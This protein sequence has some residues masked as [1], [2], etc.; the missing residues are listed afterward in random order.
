MEK[1]DLQAIALCTTPFVAKIKSNL[2]TTLMYHLWKMDGGTICFCQKGRALITVN[3]KEYEIVPNMQAI[4]L[5][6]SIVC[7]NERSEDFEISFFGFSKEMI[8]EVCHRFDPN[9]FH[10]IKENPCYLLS[11]ENTEFIKG[12]MYAA[13]AIYKDKENR[14]REQIVRNH[15][16]TFMLEIYD[17]CYRYLGKNII[18]GGNRQDEVFNKFIALVH[19]NCITQREVNFYADRLCI[20]CKYLTDICRSVSGD[21]TKKIIDDFTILE[22]KVMLQSDKITMQEIADQFRFPDQSYLGRYFKRHEG[23]SLKEYKKNCRINKPLSATGKTDRE[24][25]P[26]PNT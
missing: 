26:L 16:Q 19:E 3:L 23:I 6:G 10:F 18:E 17:K 13:S 5:P 2:P 7:I 15:L 24:S 20:S 9:F 25:A 8:R 22:I 4:F 11:E 1:T 21:S 14:F 12:L